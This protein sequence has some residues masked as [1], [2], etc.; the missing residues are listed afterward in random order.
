[1]I[2]EIERLKVGLMILAVGYGLLIS[3]AGVWLG[4]L[5]ERV[6]KLENKND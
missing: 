2:D 5:L 6:R 1:M 3:V 4:L